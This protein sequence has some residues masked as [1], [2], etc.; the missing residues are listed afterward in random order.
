MVGCPQFALPSSLSTYL[1]ALIGLCVSLL[2]SQILY[3][4]MGYSSPSVSPVKLRPIF[5]VNFTLVAK[6]QPEPFSRFSRGLLSLLQRSNETF[7]RAHPYLVS[8]QIFYLNFPIV[9]V[10]SL[11]I[12]VNNPS[13]GY[14]SPPLGEFPLPGGGR[15]FLH[16]FSILRGLQPLGS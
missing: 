10:F 15:A 9:L 3:R 8:H 11:P 1:C 5:W 2:V 6:Q 7:D 13:C 16:P 4:S 14:C 12:C